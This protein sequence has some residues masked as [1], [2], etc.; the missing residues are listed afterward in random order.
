ML[1]SGGHVLTTLFRAQAIF[2]GPVKINRG[3]LALQ[4]TLGKTIAGGR[5]AGCGRGILLLCASAS[6]WVLLARSVAA[7][8][9]S[10][11]RP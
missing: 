11:L 4:A 5:R 3:F 7:A 9:E 10:A 6:A 2:S 1:R 8:A